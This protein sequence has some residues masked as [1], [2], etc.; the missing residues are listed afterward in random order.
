VIVD[1]VIAPLIVII[2][3]AAAHDESANLPDRWKAHGRVVP[4]HA[5]TSIHARDARAILAV[6]K[7]AGGDLGFAR[8]GRSGTRGQRAA[9][10]A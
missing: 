10:L 5:K 1:P 8:I 2:A 3:A 9:L 6:D 4:P 7:K